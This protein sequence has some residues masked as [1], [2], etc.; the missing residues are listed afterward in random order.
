VARPLREQFAIA[1]L[2]LLVP[3]TVVVTWAAGTTYGEQLVQ[4]GRE[5]NALAGA[6]AAHIDRAP[7]SEDSLGDFLRGIPLP[8]GAVVTITGADARIVAEHRSGSN[9]EELVYGSVTASRVPLRVSVGIPTAVAWWRA[10]P[11]YR[12]T[13][14]ITGAATLIMLLLEALF[15][16][17][18]LSALVHLEKNA[19][20]VGAGD[21]RT[22]PDEP[23]PAR[24][25]EHLR[26]AFRDMVDKLRAAHDAI[27]RQV[28]EERRMR[29]EVQL[30]QQQIIRQERLAAIGVLLS[31][32]AHELNNPLQSI[33]GFAQ[34]L[35][36]DKEVNQAARADLALIQKESAR[37]SA[38]IRNLSRFSRQQGST[39]TEVYLRDIVASVVELRQRQCQEQGITLE[40][41]EQSIEP[42]TAVFTEIQQVLLNFVI[43]AEQA[44]R[45]AKSAERRIMIRTADRDGNVC[46]EVEDTG[47]GVPRD[48]E[49]KLFQPFFTTKPVGEGTGLGL[50]VSY[51]IIQ[52]CHGTI[53]YRR[54]ETGG[55]IF[56][57][58]LPIANKA[59]EVTRQWGNE[60]IRSA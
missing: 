26:D 46:L 52:A 30:L 40:A 21:L 29:E 14:A 53:G 39:P 17:R 2:L 44:I 50:S 56:H 57:V 58:E 13:I 3:V 18:W 59:N 5:A 36:R 16:R 8:T 41:D 23:M 33:S 37:A 42:T 45:T 48:D 12:R 49:S 55:A 38:I 34:L 7:G 6:V 27:A 24:E 28:E 60:Q 20:R 10:G 25:L 31:G 9:I 35:Q 54:R 32:I 51:G 47:P 11:I 4:L 1:S 19:D 15:V 22:P 43:N